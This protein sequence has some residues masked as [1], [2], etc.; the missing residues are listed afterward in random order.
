M[1]HGRLHRACALVLGVGL[2]LALTPRDLWAWTPGTHIHLGEAVL[3]M[4]ALL[5]PATAALLRTFPQDF[6]YGSIAADTSI[7]KKYAPVG[8]H[9]HSWTVGFEILDEARDEPLRAFALGYLAHLAADVVAHNFFVP[10]QLAVTSST[11]SIGHSYWESRFET[12][13]GEAPARR[14]REIVLLDHARADAHL[15][16]I[17]SPTIFS[18]STNRRLFRGMVYVSDTESWQRLYRIVTENSR[19]TLGAPLV[20][21]HLVRS[22]DYVMDLLTRL[23]GA[24]PFAFDPSG[25]DALRLAKR[26]RRSALR[27]GDDALRDEAEKLFGLPAS[28]LDHAARLDRPLY[29]DARVESS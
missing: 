23:D 10:R 1:T 3:R 15:D 5:P 20:Q 9:C 11:A 8:R 28:S 21:A 22:F 27:R 25:D 6:L 16:R 17:L 26:L 2:V 12:H 24:E 7:A 18:T 13:L 19:W 14:A 4:L 29:P